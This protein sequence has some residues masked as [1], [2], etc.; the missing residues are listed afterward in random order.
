M[1]YVGR[2]QLLCPFFLSLF[3]YGRPSGLG[4]K[5]HFR[6]TSVFCCNDYCQRE[7]GSVMFHNVLNFLAR[8]PVAQYASR[9]PVL[10]KVIVFQEAKRVHAF[11]VD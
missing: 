9:S 1:Q 7:G 3:E 11:Y 2:G 8:D 5:G 6:V 10:D 4:I